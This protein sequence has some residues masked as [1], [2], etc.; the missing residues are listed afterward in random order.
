MTGVAVDITQ[1]KQMEQRLRIA[2]VA[3]DTQAG[4]IITDAHKT[5][6]SA[7]QAFTA[8]TGYSAE[9]VIGHTPFFL[10][11]GLHDDNYYANIWTSVAKNGHWEGEIWDKR[12]NDEIFPTWETISRVIDSNGFISHYVA[13]LTDISVQKQA[14]KV[15]LDARQRLENQVASTQ[16]ELD[17]IREESLKINNTLDIL[18]KYRETDKYQAQDALSREVESTI[19][20]FLKRL[21]IA[22][23]NRNQARLLDI[24]EANLLRLVTCYGRDNSLSSIYQKLTPSEVQVA[25]LIRQGLSTKLIAATLHLSTGTVCI[26]RKHIRKKLGLIGS[27]DN[28][29]G[30]LLSLAD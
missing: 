25:S 27:D 12:K 21:K 4:I 14:E 3:F 9:E 1:R 28:L 22:H 24:I 10:R 23:T 7:N 5:I 19:L 6:I 8:I 15:L 30:Y 16:E 17:K 13:S 26:H 2:A 20:P 11:S 29:Y 18:L